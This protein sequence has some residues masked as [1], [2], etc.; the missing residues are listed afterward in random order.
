MQGA[1]VRQITGEE[2]QRLEERMR[3]LTHATSMGDKLAF[4]HSTRI[5]FNLTSDCISP[6]MAA[7]EV[8]LRNPVVL[9]LVL[10]SVL[11]RIMMLPCG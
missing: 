6:L 2:R 8:T 1:P 5:M 7:Y 10:F 4:K 11:A 9:V 3:Y